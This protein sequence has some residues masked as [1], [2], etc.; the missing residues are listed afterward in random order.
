AAPH[1]PR[2]SSTGADRGAPCEGTA[3]ARATRARDR[4]YGRPV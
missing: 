2:H 1:R 3:P 4:F